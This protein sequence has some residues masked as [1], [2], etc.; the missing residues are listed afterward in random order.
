MFE[1]LASADQ[2]IAMMFLA[3][4]IGIVIASVVMAYFSKKR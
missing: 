3:M 4:I 2:T 1:D